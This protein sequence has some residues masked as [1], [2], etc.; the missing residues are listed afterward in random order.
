MP[1]QS[2][3]AN[4]PP[5]N[6][7]SD[8]FNTI[9]NYSS[10]VMV[11]DEKLGTDQVL[12]GNDIAFSQVGNYLTKSGDDLILKVNGSNSDKITVKDFFLGGAHE[13]ESFNFETGGSISS[14]QI[15]QV[16]GVD[17]PVNAED[18][19]TSIVMGD[20]GNNILSSDAA[21]SELFVLNEGN[22]ILELL[23]NASGETPVDFVTDF[24]MTEDQIDLS[25][26]L[27]NHANSSNLSDYIEIIYDANAKTNTLSAR[28]QPTELS[29]DLL[30]FTNQAD[31]LSIA[32]LTMNQ[33]IIY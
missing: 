4:I 3:P 28:N 7:D 27:D 13:V 21:V 14:Q 26:I 12:F 32:D 15:Y 29:K 30:I 19:V 6:I 1:Q 2:A 22:D 8:A 10:G 16:F 25:Q 23:L 9:Y 31:S 5:E 20:S 18:E 33:S 11:I 24:D 17:R